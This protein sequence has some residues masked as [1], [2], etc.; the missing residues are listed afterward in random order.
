MIYKISKVAGL[1]FD[2]TEYT[3]VSLTPPIVLVLQLIE[4]T[5]N[6]VG[7][8]AGIFGNLQIPVDPYYLLQ[9]YVPQIDWDIFK[10]KAEE[11]Q[12]QKAALSSGDEKQQG[13]SGMGW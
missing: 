13:G 4:S 10:K 11:Y 6:S 3:S 1:D 5:L 9:Q 12:K 7:N 8:I 2:P